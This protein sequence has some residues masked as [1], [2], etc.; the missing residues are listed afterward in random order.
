MAFYLAISSSACVEHVREATEKSCEQQEAKQSFSAMQ[1]YVIYIYTG[2]ARSK[3]SFLTVPWA[4]GASQP[5]IT[6][7]YESSVG[8]S[9]PSY[10]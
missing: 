4:K 8:T 7:W 1:C 6:G 3:K 5:N 9:Y 10:T 2:T